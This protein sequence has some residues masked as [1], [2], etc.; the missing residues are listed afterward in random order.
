MPS[1]AALQCVRCLCIGVEALP[2]ALNSVLRTVTHLELLWVHVIDTRDLTSPLTLI[3]HLT[4]VAF[5]GALPSA[6]LLGALS[7]DTRL[8]CI[9]FFVSAREV[10][11]IRSLAADL[12]VITVE[13]RFLRTLAE[14]GGR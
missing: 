9:V 8:Q 13:E 5:H 7:A 10:V 1:L 6:I 3:P 4:H 2:N 14:R 12:P 11:N